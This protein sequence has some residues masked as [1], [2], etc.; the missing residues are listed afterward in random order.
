[1]RKRMLFLGNLFLAIT[2]AV[3]FGV[4]VI[5]AI[6]TVGSGAAVV[7]EPWSRAGE[8][9][10]VAVGSLAV[11]FVGFK[12]YDLSRLRLRK[13][14]VMDAFP[15][16]TDRTL[17][18]AGGMLIAVGF[19]ALFTFS[20]IS[21]DKG[22]NPASVHDRGVRML[23]EGR[24][25]EAVSTFT[26]VIALDPSREYLE[27]ALVNRSIALF[28]LG[29][30]EE[31]LADETILI[32]LGPTVDGVLVRAHL[33][34]S[35]ELI[36]LGRHEEALADAAVVIELQPASVVCLGGAYHN[37]SIAFYD[38]GQFDEALEAAAAVI[39]L[40]PNAD[41]LARAHRRR[42]LIFV[43]LNQAADVVA[44]AT[45][46]I[47]LAPG[48]ARILAEAYLARAAGLGELGEYEDAVVDVGTAI[49]LLS[50]DDPMAQS[51]AELLEEIELLANLFQDGE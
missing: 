39:D 28:E 21:G 25:D 12:T 9:L 14:G 17:K 2:A 51:A 23:E 46:A 30:L 41:L 31:A 36:S 11:S 5:A 15:I 34:R 26:E 37:R 27:T 38:L 40:E 29:R 13:T 16:L 4:S 48:D 7:F 24:W 18:I 20:A 49:D 50:D 1:M 10:L 35:R 44:E 6:L 22:D 33:N 3:G 42:Y 8:N 19:V 43:E 47:D 45:A 32:D